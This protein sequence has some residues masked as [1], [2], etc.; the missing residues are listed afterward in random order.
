MN[1][2]KKFLF[3]KEAVNI[4]GHYAK[5]IICLIIATNITV[6]VNSSTKVKLFIC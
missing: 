6:I 4:S 1:D 3:W 5:S 2:G